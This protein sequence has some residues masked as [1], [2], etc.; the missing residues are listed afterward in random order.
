MLTLVL[1]IIIIVW[2]Q[3][4]CHGVTEFQFLNPQQLIELGAAR[5]SNNAGTNINVGEINPNNFLTYAMAHS[6]APPNCHL[7]SVDM[8]EQGGARRR[9][10]DTAQAGPP[11]W[12][13]VFKDFEAAYQ[14]QSAADVEIRRQDWIN[15]ADGTAVDPM[16]WLPNQPAQ[17]LS[18][19]TEETPY[20]AMLVP[21]AGLVGATPTMTA[22]GAYYECCAEVLPSC[23]GS[24]LESLEDV[25]VP[26]LAQTG[27]GGQEPEPMPMRRA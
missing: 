7:A 19:D 21:G 13:G 14:D 9:L 4:V 18:D 26:L 22:G 23:F 5:L 2:D 20:V 17:V 12:V 10:S 16:L 1:V 25:L 8:Q 15:V 3:C 11:G 24:G 27:G 6:L